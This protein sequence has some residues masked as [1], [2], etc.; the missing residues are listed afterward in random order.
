[1]CYLYKFTNYT[2]WG[3]WWLEK[4]NHDPVPEL[5]AYALTQSFSHASHQSGHNSLSPIDIMCYC[6]T[7]E[8]CCNGWLYA[9]AYSYLLCT[10]D[11]THL[12]SLF[13]HQLVITIVTYACDGS[14]DGPILSKLLSNK[15]HSV[16]SIYVA[17]LCLII[18]LY[19]TLLN[20]TC[21]HLPR[22]SIE[23]SMASMKRH[24]ALLQH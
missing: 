21:I 11:C 10:L 7:L 8:K 5:A 3:K 12:F 16:C 9:I 2:V 23:C 18:Y 24:S 4:K 1:M 6:V 17:Y 13:S 14:T 20:W 15:Q 22:E 19:L